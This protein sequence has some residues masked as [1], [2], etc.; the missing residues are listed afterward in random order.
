MRALLALGASTMWVG[1][2]LLLG[3]SVAPAAFAALPSPALAGAIV[4]RVLPV[5]FIS[6]FV[7]AIVI[8]VRGLGDRGAGQGPVRAAAAV[9]TLACGLAQFGV[10]PAITRVHN[11]VGGPIDALAMT[12]PQRVAFGRLHLASVGLLILGVLAALAVAGLA[13]S[14]ARTTSTH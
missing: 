12:D 5:V 13:A 7:L 3:A 9:W 4:G 1:A 11:S 2:A 10:S 8:G 6:G 14:A